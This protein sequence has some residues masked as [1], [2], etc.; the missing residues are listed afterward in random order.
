MGPVKIKPIRLLRRNEIM[1]KWYQLAGQSMAF[2]FNNVDNDFMPIEV[3]TFYTVPGR[4]YWTVSVEGLDN[5]YD[6]GREYRIPTFRIALEWLKNYEKMK[7]YK[8]DNY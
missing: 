8:Y 7:N 4:K 1:N 3:V 5:S 2:S 6:G